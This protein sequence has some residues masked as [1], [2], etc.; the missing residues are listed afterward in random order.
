MA[1]KAVHELVGHHAVGTQEVGTVKAPCYCAGLL[2]LKRQPA[3][4]G[5]RVGD[6]G[7]V[8]TGSIVGVDEAFRRVETSAPQL[9]AAL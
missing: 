9:T 5:R 6:C 4:A 3:N 1:L 2:A 7:P 8:V